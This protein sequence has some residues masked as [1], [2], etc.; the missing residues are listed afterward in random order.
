MLSYVFYATAKDQTATIIELLAGGKATITSDHLWSLSTSHKTSRNLY[1]R[2]AKPVIQWGKQKKPCFLH[3]LYYSYASCP[4]LS[5]FHFPWYLFVPCPTELLLRNSTG[6]IYSCFSK[7]PVSVHYLAVDTLYNGLDSACLSVRQIGR[8]NQRSI[9]LFPL[10]L[11][12][13]WL[14][15][16]CLYKFAR[17][18]K[19]CRRMQCIVTSDPFLWTASKHQQFWGKSLSWRVH[20]QP[21]KIWTSGSVLK[22]T[23]CPV[24]PSLPQRTC[25]T[26]AII[27][28]HLLYTME[29][30]DIASS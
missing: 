27:P 30:A 4:L 9:G 11:Y 20:I 22:V 5:P 15:A 2:E 23:N 8:Q 7:L 10:L 12:S 24:V 29:N 26:F 14:C 18:R 16:L 6:H 17:R 3:S 1:G 13:A 25:P 21:H 19:P 28:G